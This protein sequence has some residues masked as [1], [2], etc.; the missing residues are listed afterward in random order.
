MQCVLFI[1]TQKDFKIMPRARRA[2]EL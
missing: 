1:A 2:G